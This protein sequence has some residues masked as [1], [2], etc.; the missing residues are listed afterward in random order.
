MEAT[1]VKSWMEQV[2]RPEEYEKY[3]DEDGR[4]FIHEDEIE[5]LLNTVTGNHCQIGRDSNSDLGR[6]RRSAECRRSRLMGRDFCRCAAHQTEGIRTAYCDLCAALHFQL[7]RQQLPLL[8][9][10]FGKRR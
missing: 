2:I 9:F 4:D 10:S 6:V 5:S 7:L 3:L 8:R 1:K